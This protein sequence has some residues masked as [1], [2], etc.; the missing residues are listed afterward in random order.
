MR[1]HIRK[2][3][4]DVNADVA[5]YHEAYIKAAHG[6]HEIEKLVNGEMK[7]MAEAIAADARMIKEAGIA[8][9]KRIE[10]EFVSTIVTTEQFILLLSIGGVIL[11]AILAWQ[12]GRMI[13]RPVVALVPILKKLCEGDFNVMTL[14]HGDTEIGRI[15]SLSVTLRFPLGGSWRLAPRFTVERLSGL[16]D[17]GNETSYIPSALLDYQHGNILVQLET[18]A[19]LGSREAFLQLQ[20][21]QFVQTQKTTRYYASL[22][23]RVTF[24]N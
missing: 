4:E 19:Q 6:A 18:G 3:F 13:S 10:E 20:N 15:D 7:E 9:E 17:G 22:S 14:Q 11:G 16:S 8:E 1:L 23:Y 21:G 2:L 12:I 5:K 24:Q